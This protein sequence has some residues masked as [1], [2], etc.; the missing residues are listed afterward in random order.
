MIVDNLFYV[1]LHTLSM[2]I[3]TTTQYLIYNLYIPRVCILE[4]NY[5]KKQ[6]S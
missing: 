6:V 3:L 1:V 2:Y 4:A 5:V